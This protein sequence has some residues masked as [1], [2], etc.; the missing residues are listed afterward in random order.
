MT[1]SVPLYESGSATLSN[2]LTCKG[3]ASGAGA[4]L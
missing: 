3:A 4:V 1:T 2:I